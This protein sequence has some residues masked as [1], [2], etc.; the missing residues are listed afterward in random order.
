MMRGASNNDPA[1]NTRSMRGRI[2]SS[3]RLLG[4]SAA[5]VVV[6]LGTAGKRSGPMGRPTLRGSS[7]RAARAR[8]A[9]GTAR[10]AAPPRAA[11]GPVF[12]PQST[13]R[14]DPP[15]A[16]T[17]DAGARHPPAATPR[18]RRR[19]TATA[20][21]STSP[22]GSTA[23]EKDGPVTQESGAAD[24]IS[25]PAQPDITR[26]PAVAG[27]PGPD[28]AQ[29]PSQPASTNTN[30]AVRVSSPGDNGPVSQDNG[31]NALPAQPAV[32]GPASAAAA[33]DPATD[34]AE[35]PDDSHAVSR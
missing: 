34:A 15:P 29:E 13:P 27:I 4:A 2:P 1:V 7:P 32:D 35:R 21:T 11:P 10:P 24:V 23:Q 25:P 28:P 19:R 12:E 14:I 9:A 5:M 3:V 20:G 16:P 6:G 18:S 26:D 30:V 31:A 8:S 17:P 22:F 33:S